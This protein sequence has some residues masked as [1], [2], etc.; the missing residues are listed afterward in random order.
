MVLYCT[1]LQEADNMVGFFISTQ[2]LIESSGD[3]L[4]F[5]YLKQLQL[6]FKHSCLCEDFFLSQRSFPWLN[7]GF[8]Q[9]EISTIGSNQM[10]YVA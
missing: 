10:Y 9:P 4:L 3:E 5:Y 1:G 7:S 8:Y 6:C 2:I